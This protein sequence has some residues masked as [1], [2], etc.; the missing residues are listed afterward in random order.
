M[1]NATQNFCS[2]RRNSP[3]TAASRL[4]LILSCATCATGFAIGCSCA[5]ACG[6]CGTLDNCSEEQRTSKGIKCFK[7][8]LRT[9]LPPPSEITSTLAA[10]TKPSEPGN[11]SATLQSFQNDLFDC[12]FLRRQTSLTSIIRI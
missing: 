12:S 2:R 5:V 3:I 7:D 4:F 8:I 10:R 1:L 9:F 6:S 11:N